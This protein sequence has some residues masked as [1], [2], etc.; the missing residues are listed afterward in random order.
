MSANETDISNLKLVLHGHDQPIH[1]SL[2]VEY[3]AVVAKNARYTVRSLI[4]PAGFSSLLSWPL[5][6][7][8]LRDLLLFP[9]GLQCLDR[10]NSHNLG[11]V[12]PFWEQGS[13]STSLMA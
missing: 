1:I 6:T 8:L 2:N 5:Y 7:M 10:D 9:K 13:C 12:F 4:C 11:C 3:D